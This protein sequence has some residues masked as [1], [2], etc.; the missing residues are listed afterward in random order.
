MIAPINPHGEEIRAQRILNSLTEYRKVID[1]FGPMSPQGEQIRAQEE[2]AEFAPK[3][4][5]NIGQSIMRVFKAIK[6]NR[7]PV[8]DETV[9]RPV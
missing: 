8:V 4:N 7:Y 9:Q 5:H 2:T 1:T 3:A 6:L